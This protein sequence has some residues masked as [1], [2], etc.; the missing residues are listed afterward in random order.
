[1]ASIPQLNKDINDLQAQIRELKAENE[2]LRNRPV[3]VREKRV[4]VPV[5]VVKVV[6][7]PVEV[8]VNAPMKNKLVDELRARIKRLEAEL[9]KKPKTVTLSKTE[10]R[11]MNV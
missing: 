5:Q 1:M 8:F 2:E 4:E 10:R 6:E 7:K 3:E 11:R 9:L